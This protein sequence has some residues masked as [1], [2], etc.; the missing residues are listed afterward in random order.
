LP[1]PC[2]EFSHDERRDQEDAQGDH[3]LGI[4]DVEGVKE[5]SEKVVVDRRTQHGDDARKPGTDDP[6]TW[7]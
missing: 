5:R 7:R 4:G 6:G 3:V 1:Y 2:R